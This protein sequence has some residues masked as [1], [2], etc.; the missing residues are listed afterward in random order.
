[1]NW[2]EYIRREDW[3]ERITRR[4][5]TNLWATS[6]PIFFMCDEEAGEE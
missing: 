6:E 3:F 4:V 5:G 1:M 2:E